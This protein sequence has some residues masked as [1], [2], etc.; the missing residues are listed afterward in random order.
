M[1]IISI[2]HIKKVKLIMSTNS[3]PVLSNTAEDA[4][5]AITRFQAEAANLTH[6]LAQFRAW[7]AVQDHQGNWTFGPSKFIGYVGLNAEL[8]GEAEAMMDGRDTEATL[9][10]WFEEEP[11]DTSL[12]RELHAKLAQYLAGF[13]KKKNSKTRINVLLN[14]PADG[15]GDDLE[16]KVVDL[17]DAVSKL[18]SPSGRAKLRKRFA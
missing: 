7:Y 1:K 18:L 15:N 3:T 10:K 11:E 12:G 5:N 16:A 4:L 9:Q 8:Y 2:T 14:A 13:G 17:I 6:R